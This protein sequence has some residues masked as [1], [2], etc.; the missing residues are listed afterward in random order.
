MP[1]DLLVLVAAFVTGLL[2]SAHCGAMCGGI[3]IA[4]ALPAS[5]VTAPRSPL[6]LGMAALLPNLGRIGSYTVAGAAVGGLG[7]GLLGALDLTAFSSWLRLGVGLVLLLAAVRLAAPRWTARL[8]SGPAVPLWQAITPLRRIVPATGPW[9]ALALGALWGWLPCG[10][11]YTLLGAAWLEG[12][13][14][15]GALLMLAFGLGTLPALAALAT[16]GLRWGASSR[17]SWGRH[18]GALLVGGAGMLTLSAPWLVHIPAL[19]GTLVALGC[20]SLGS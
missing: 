10:L 18:A 9:R 4:T 13:A 15:H 5:P 2:G 1:L 8:P 7:G 17:A 6:V 12:S 14:L 3:A 19:H 20:R 11:S 16:V